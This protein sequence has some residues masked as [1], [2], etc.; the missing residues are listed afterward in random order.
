MQFCYLFS[1]LLKKPQQQKNKR[2]VCHAPVTLEH[3]VT[4]INRWNCTMKTNWRTRSRRWGWGAEKWSLLWRCSVQ[5]RQPSKTVFGFVVADL[6]WAGTR[7]HL[8]RNPCSCTWKALVLLFWNREIN[9]CPSDW[10]RIKK[11]TTATTQHQPWMCVCVC[12]S[13]SL[14]AQYA[15]R[16]LHTATCLYEGSRQTSYEFQ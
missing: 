14:S 1:I 5:Q 13:A 9:K 7:W 4:Y 2:H 11:H 6:D 8:F 16:Y 3:I 10:F 12:V 15:V